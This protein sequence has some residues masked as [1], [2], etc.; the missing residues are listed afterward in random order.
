MGKKSVRA[1][2]DIAAALR[3][4][5]S[6]LQQRPALGLQADAPATARWDGGLRVLST[7]AN[8][9]QIATDMPTA[10]GGSGDAVS[11]GWLLRAALAGC[12]ATRIAMAAAADGIELTA[13]LVS[14]D[15]RSDTR[16]LLGMQDAGGDAVDAGP[17]D[18]QVSVDIAAHGVAA[19]RLE[20]LVEGAN[21]LSPVSRALQNA[22]PVNLRITVREA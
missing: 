6:I 20:R 19:A 15:S 14:A 11:P 16:G 22:A 13:L 12:L 21:R 5:E 10:M 4:V 3:R 17:C 2:E 9:Q 7:D 18:L 8:G 1:A